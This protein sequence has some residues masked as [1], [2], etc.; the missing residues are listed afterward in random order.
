MQSIQKFTNQKLIFTV[1][2]LNDKVAKL[3]KGKFKFKVFYD[4]S[5]EKN[6]YSEF[7]INIDLNNKILE[8]NEKDQDYRENILKAFI[9]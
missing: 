9:Q 1:F 3:E 8:L 2:P 7:Y 6:L 4:D 5:N